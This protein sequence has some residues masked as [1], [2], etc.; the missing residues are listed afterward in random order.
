MHFAPSA[1]LAIAAATVFSSAALAEPVPEFDIPNSLVARADNLP[2]SIPS[3]CQ[4]PCQVL[5]DLQKCT[6][7]KC[8]CNDQVSD[9][10]AGCYDCVAATFNNAT[11]TNVLQAGFDG[12][13]NQCKA[14]GAPI[15][16]QTITANGALRNVGVGMGVVGV[17]L[18]LLLSAM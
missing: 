11:Q 6:D 16:S 3:Q 1:V 8:S 7:T 14:A 12:Y 4:S 15:K 18:G 13:A 10:L 17:V 2:A 9:S 5:S